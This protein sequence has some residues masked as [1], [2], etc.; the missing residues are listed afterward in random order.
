MSFQIPIAFLVFNRPELTARVWAAIAEVKPATLLIVGDG[1][2]TDRID[3]AERVALVRACVQR[4]DWPCD[5]RTNF[6]P[7]NLGCKQ[8][9]ASG[10]AWVFQSVEEAIILEDDCLPDRTFFPYCQQ[11]LQRYRD[12]ERI[13]VIS[14]D[15]FQSGVRRTPYSYYFSK[16]FHCWGW[17]SWRRV[18]KHFDVTMSS[19]PAW[20]NGNALCSWVDSPLEEW[21]WT[22]IFEQAYQGRI[23]SWDYAWLY[24][25]WRQG[26]LTI[27][28]EVNLV[29]NIGFGS[30]AVHTHDPGNRFSNLSTQPLTE[31]HH[32]PSV[33]RHEE[34]DRFTFSTHFYRDT[35]RRRLR[36]R[37]RRWAD[38]LRSVL[39]WN[40]HRPTESP[41]AGGPEPLASGR[42]GRAAGEQRSLP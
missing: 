7:V 24:A 32:P 4:V 39:R 17:A 37:F 28:P 38:G 1:P 41:R 40:R 6:S 25:C 12:D 19:W 3:E 18:W 22:Q 8:R 33:V 16:Y 31:I 2:R 30:D 36:R 23:D 26:G 20:R 35:L 10:L 27:L 5:V 21:Y 13:A 42:P 14:G 34:A 15:N 11:L 29:S 9:I